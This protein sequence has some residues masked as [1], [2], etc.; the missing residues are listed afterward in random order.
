MRHVAIRQ[1]NGALFQEAAERGELVGITNDK[2][3]AAVLVPITPGWIDQIIEDHFTRLLRSIESGQKAVANDVSLTSLDDFKALGTG[4]LPI[5]RRV[6]IRELSGELL[7]HAAET[8][9][10]LGV[11]ND[12]RLCAVVLP[13]TSA[14]V[15]RLI[16]HNVSRLIQSVSWGQKAIDG[17]DPLRSFDDARPSPAAMAVPTP[18]DSST[19]VR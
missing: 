2:Q 3:L 7:S 13:V 5:T 1:L 10:I 15:D 14:W 9:E 8:G 4:D 19:V 12:R 17:D 18:L 16:D 6:A 11:L